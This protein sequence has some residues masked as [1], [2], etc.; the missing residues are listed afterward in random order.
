LVKKSWRIDV[1]KSEL[2][3]IIQ[4]LQG[5]SNPQLH[6]EQYITDAVATADLLYHIAFEQQDLMG[7]LI[8]D[9]GCGS[10]N[11]SIAAALLGAIHVVAV[12]IDT[13]IL[14]ILNQNLHQLEL[15]NQFTVIQADI[16]TIDISSQI[17]DIFTTQ[18]LTQSSNLRNPQI[19]TNPVDFSSKIVTI[20]NPPFGVHQ[21]GI[22]VKFLRTALSF[23]DIVY[24]IHLSN[25]KSREYLTQKIHQ[26]GGQI[27]EMATLYL[28]IKESYAHHKR[29]IKKIA[30]DV[31][32]IT[33]NHS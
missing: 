18:I 29:H 23:S 14:K 25:E 20:S 22:D 1:K 3:D 8:V 24:S 4:H 11:L 17:H 32:R 6:L 26:F 5:F 7:N 12:D 10:G 21:K 31:Y 13:E 2:I 27:T 28:M 30:A 19:V 15:E 33:K 9:L 16:R